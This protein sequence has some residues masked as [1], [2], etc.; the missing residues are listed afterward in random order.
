MAQTT[1]KEKMKDFDDVVSTFKV[2][3]TIN[4]DRDVQGIYLI[5]YPLIQK[6][7]KEI[8]VNGEWVR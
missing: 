3:N 2:R 6:F 1:L 4:M 8:V 5:Q 7:G